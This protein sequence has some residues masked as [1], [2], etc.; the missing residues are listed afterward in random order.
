MTRITLTNQKASNWLELALRI[1]ASLSL[2]MSNSFD[3][4]GLLVDSPVRVASNTECFCNVICAPTMV[5]NGIHLC[6]TV[7]EGR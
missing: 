2:A 7:L 5:R 6:K 3:F 4:E 1:T